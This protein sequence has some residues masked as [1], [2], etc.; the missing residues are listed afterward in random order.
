M[1][2]Q[3]KKPTCNLLSGVMLIFEIM[4]TAGVWLSFRSKDEGLLAVGFI[5]GCNAI[6]VCS[7]L[8]AVFAVV[9]LARREAW[10]ALSLAGLVLNSGP[11]V[12][13]LMHFN[14]RLFRP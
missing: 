14:D 3:R 8:G 13:L 5:I 6:L 4:I 12:F 2:I 1:T 11:L 10:L 9:A 7:A